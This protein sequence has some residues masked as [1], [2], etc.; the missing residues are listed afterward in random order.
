[1]SKDSTTKVHD[2][3]MTDGKTHAIHKHDMKMADMD[4]GEMDM[5]SM[6]MGGRHHMQMMSVGLWR[7]RL[8]IAIVLAL[9]MCYY[10][11]ADAIGDRMPFYDILRPYMAPLSFLAATAAMLF[12]GASFFRSTVA[13]LRDRT[14][15]MDSL[16]TIGTTTAYVYSWVSYL[17]YIMVQKRIT[18][19]YSFTMPHLYFETV[20]F[21]FLFVILGKYLE[22]K[23]T[24]QTGKSIRSLLKLRPH[25]AHL[26]NG[27]HITDIP[28]KHVKAGDHLLVKPGEIIPIDGTV[29]EGSTNTDESMITGES[30]AVD[31][32][33][34]DKVIAGTINGH[35]AVEIVA[36]TS[37]NGTVLSRIIRMIKTAQNN[38]APIEDLSDR[39]SAVFVPFVIMAALVTLFAWYYVVGIDMSTAMMYFVAVV[40]IACPCAFGLATPTA[41]TVGIGQG[42]KRGILIKGGLALQKLHKVNAVVFDKTGT[43]TVG[44]PVVTDVVPVRGTAK[45]AM[46]IAASLEKK[47]EHSMARAILSYAKRAHL[48]T[49]A[50]MKFQ[51]IPGKGIAGNIKGKTYYVG[52]ESLAREHVKVEL[53]DTAKLRR[54]SKSISYLF[55]EDGVIAVI[56]IADQPKPSAARTIRTLHKMRIETYL[57]SGDSE[58]TAKAIA[59][60]LGIK[61][62]I[63]NVVP[64]EKVASIT[65]LQSE[66]KVVAMVGDGI[67]DAP[68]I[69]TAD[70]GVAIGTGTDVAIEAGDVV[71]VSGDPYDICRALN[72]SHATVH[73]IYQNLFFSMFYNIISIPLAA[74]ALSSFGIHLR[75]ELA[76]LIMALS[77]VAV[78][79]NSLALKTVRPGKPD[80]VGVLAP[81]SLFLLFSAFYVMFIIS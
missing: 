76:G 69:A 66:G 41:V 77:S 67:N 73:K 40:M 14:F 50:V 47:S 57:L 7:R 3:K 23:A 10:M 55:D 79:L 5:P 44:K 74:G 62:V 28:T 68:A 2:M 15:N 61:H 45:E 24:D 54:A 78:V 60:R 36:L 32:H 65:K 20:V 18:M 25:R 4:M 16:I 35:G 27:G 30:V 63:S 75:P 59:N 13:G 31:K 48:A 64:S 43:L 19:D 70:V 26:V 39:I 21:L 12:L 51:A 17:I 34:G 46:M 38:R 6:R 29:Y 33:V 37:E 9:P 56:A 1:M 58:A 53:P 52:N 22:A 72:L 81:T 8:I 49:S 71:L 42:S 11:L 80:I